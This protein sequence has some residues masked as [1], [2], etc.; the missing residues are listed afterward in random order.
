MTKYFEC[1]QCGLKGDLEKGL[2]KRKGSKNNY[3]W[4]TNCPN[5]G[6]VLATYIEKDINVDC[7]EKDLGTLGNKRDLT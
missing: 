1:P 4:E 2:F 7:D 6:V 5:C 3:E